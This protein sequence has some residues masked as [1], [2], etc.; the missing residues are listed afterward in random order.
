MTSYRLV[1]EKLLT[2]LIE[3]G[4]VRPVLSAQFP[5]NKTARIGDN[6]TF[7]CIELFSPLLTDYI[8]LH[9]NRLPPNYPDLGFGDDPPLLNSTYYKG[10]NPRH[11]QA[12]R[13]QKPEKRYGGRVLLTNVTKEDEGMYTCVV[14]N[15]VGKGWRSAF[16]RVLNEG[17]YRCISLSGMNLTNMSSRLMGKNEGKKIS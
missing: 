5:V 15:H 3:K 13:V 9:W 2:I 4:P 6:V 17:W 16:L 10:I 12:F 11:L 8:W 7:Q 1:V 14:S